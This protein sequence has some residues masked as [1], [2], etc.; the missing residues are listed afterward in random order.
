M[1]D[2]G[3]YNESFDHPENRL[4]KD[5]P[6]TP[7]LRLHPQSSGASFSHNQRP[8]RRQ[9]ACEG[10][11]STHHESAKN[12][13]VQWKFCRF[14]SCILFSYSFWFYTFRIAYLLLFQ[15]VLASDAEEKLVRDLFRDYNKLIRPVELINE[16]LDVA[17]RVY[18]IQLINVVC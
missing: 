18:L 7:R 1:N 8:L 4:E 17:I 2:S 3:D 15:T 10:F 9:R 5:R 11:N 6:T 12:S 13:A 16:T 14:K